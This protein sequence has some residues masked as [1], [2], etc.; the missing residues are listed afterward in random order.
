MPLL[1]CADDER[2]LALNARLKKPLLQTAWRAN[3]PLP[4]VVFFVLACIGVA[5]L[6]G[7]F[8][9]IGLTAALGG[10][11]AIALAELLIVRH[12]W[13]RTGVE[14]ALWIGG[15][16]AIVVTLGPRTADEWLI[17]CALASAIAWLRVRYALFA[18]LALAL[19]LFAIERDAIAV[20][21]VVAVIALAALARTWRRPS[22][23]WLFIA[24]LLVAPVVAYL[25][26]RDAA[27]AIYPLFAVVCLVAGLRLRHHA[28]LLAAAIGLAIV[29]IEVHERLA[30]ATEVQLALGG[31]VLLGS[32]WLVARALRDR[33]RGIVATKESLTGADEIF[34]SGAVLMTADRSETA[35][36]QGRVQGDGR[37]GGAGATGDY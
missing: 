11:V 35:G 23:E 33:T 31:A 21:G 24:L 2:A 28:P 19:L 29:A 20:A 10:V 3:R 32:A 25:I 27:I 22:T 34:E 26:E 30:L 37:F 18:A 17:A 13:W 15:A 36:D 14:C 4:H 1:P 7:F 6:A 9:I 16:F 12:R 8:E 5:A